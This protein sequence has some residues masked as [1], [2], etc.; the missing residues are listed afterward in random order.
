MT[1]HNFYL[2]IFIGSEELEI[3]LNAVRKFLGKL[4]R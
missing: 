3:D 2:F 4:I 1:L